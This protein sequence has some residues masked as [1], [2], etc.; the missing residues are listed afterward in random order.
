MIFGNLKILNDLDDRG[1]SIICGHGFYNPVLARF[2][3]EDTYYG[4]GLNLYPE[5][6]YS[7]SYLE[8][9]NAVM[10]VLESGSKEYIHNWQHDLN[11]Y[12]KSRYGDFPSLNKGGEN[13]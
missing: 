7:K 3:S 6:M 8:Q 10:K 12:F 11:M 9:N 2:L 4:D 5:T 1:S 13:K